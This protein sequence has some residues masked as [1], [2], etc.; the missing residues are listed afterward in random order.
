MTNIR[1]FT[2]FKRK[3]VVKHKKDKKFN[4]YF[5]QFSSSVYHMQH[6]WEVSPFS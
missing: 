3:T 5:K 4:S 1:Q 6:G 2:S